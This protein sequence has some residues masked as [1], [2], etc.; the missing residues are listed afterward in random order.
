MSLSPSDSLDP[1]GHNQGPESLQQAQERTDHKGLPTAGSANLPLGSFFPLG[2][3][4]GVNIFKREE[5]FLEVSGSGYLC[6][7]DPIVTSEAH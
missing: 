3:V 4:E 1:R 2:R 6:G 5:E 7:F